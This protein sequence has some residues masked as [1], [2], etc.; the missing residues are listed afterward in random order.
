MSTN[1]KASTR[2][3]SSRTASQPTTHEQSSVPQLPDDV[4]S[5]DDGPV[6]AAMFFQQLSAQIRASEA[7]VQSVLEAFNSVREETA[8]LRR[9][10]L[11]RQEHPPP[12]THAGPSA[13]FS[14]PARFSGNDLN[15]FRAW[16]ASVRCYLDGNLNS[17]NTNKVKISW[18]ASHFTD[19]AFDWHWAEI[20]NYDLDA[21]TAW[22]TYSAALVQR[23]TDPGANEK[24]YQK[25]LSLKYEGDT[26]AYLTKFVELNTSGQSL[27]LGERSAIRKALPHRI[28]DTMNIWR[29][30]RVLSDNEFIDLL[31]TAGANYEEDRA[32][33]AATQPTRLQPPL[34][35]ESD[36]GQTKS[37]IGRLW[38]S[39]KEALAG[40]VQSAIDQRK[41]DGIQCW[42]CGRDTHHTLSCFAKQD[43]DGRDLPAAPQ[44]YGSTDVVRVAALTRH[45]EDSEA[46]MEY[47]EKAGRLDYCSSPPDFHPNL[48]LHEF[49]GEEGSPPPVWDP[50]SPRFFDEPDYES[51]F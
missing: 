12:V 13:H 31:K 49:Y 23:F 51:E 9:L 43:I 17:L 48:H 18:V 42:R 19:T 6:T 21:P 35:L 11:T 27:G 32:T 8:E 15:A 37:T 50:E 39:L 41:T 22:D 2:A 38:A 20:R 26:H 46:E 30:G 47:P 3:S 4:G 24:N 36:K 34:P 25:M 29:G 28:V 5:Q 7:H 44:R 40:I 1:G 14:K 16:W 10:V 45:S 33:S